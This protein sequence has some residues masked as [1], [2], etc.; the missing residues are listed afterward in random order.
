MLQSFETRID[1]LGLCIVGQLN[2]PT[3]IDSKKK[4]DTYFCDTLLV[5]EQPNLPYRQHP[6][7]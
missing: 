2:V 7:D 3:Q 6:V 5:K 4:V 1:S